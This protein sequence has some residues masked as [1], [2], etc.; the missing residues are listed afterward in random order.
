M[1][2][3]GEQNHEMWHTRR[4]TSART[5]ERVHTVYGILERNMHEERSKHVRKVLD[6]RYEN[7]SLVDHTRRRHFC[8]NVRVCLYCI[9]RQR[10]WVDLN[11]GG[12][13][14]DLWNSHSIRSWHYRMWS[15]IRR[16]LVSIRWLSPNGETMNEISLIH[17]SVFV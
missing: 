5:P 4:R 14:S 7:E 6:D 12:A 10:G 3:D 2:W 17:K 9:R 1:G 15:N 11:A 13:R 8:A 16:D